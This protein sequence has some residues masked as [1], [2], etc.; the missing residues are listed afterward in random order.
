[1]ISTKQ[2]MTDET[3]K[4]KIENRPAFVRIHVI[5]AALTIQYGQSYFRNWFF[6]IKCFSF[7]CMNSEFVFVLI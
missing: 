7:I 4:E 6:I 5:T 1:V 3:A 2:G